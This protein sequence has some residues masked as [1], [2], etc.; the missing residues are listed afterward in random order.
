MVCELRLSQPPSC[1]SILHANVPSDHWGEPAAAR[2]G[3]GLEAYLIRAQAVLAR[4]TEAGPALLLRG[5]DWQVMAPYLRAPWVVEAPELAH[6]PNPGNDWADIEQAYL[7]GTPEMLYIDQ[8]LH[9]VALASLRFY[10]LESK[11]WLT[12]YQGK[13]LGAFANLGFVSPLHFQIDRELRARMPK[14]FSEHPLNQ[15]WGLKNDPRRI[16]VT[17]LFDRQL[18]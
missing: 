5:D 6:A 10:C 18:G 11:L 9:P 17:Y 1:P 3:P 13:H 15:L 14:V 2:P 4:G 12:E 8:F 16:N 7:R